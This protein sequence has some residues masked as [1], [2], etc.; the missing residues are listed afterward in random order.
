MS[1]FLLSVIKAN[2]LNAPVGS[3]H[4]PKEIPIELEP[5]VLM[6][7]NNKLFGLSFFKKLHS[8]D[9]R[10]RNQRQHC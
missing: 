8:S 10:E 5:N 7:D 4:K 3:E 6:V 1:S 9:P 2:Y